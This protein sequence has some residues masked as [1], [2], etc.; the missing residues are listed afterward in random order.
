MNIDLYAEAAA[1][2][3]ASIIPKVIIMNI[4]PAINPRLWLRSIRVPGTISIIIEKIV[5]FH[6][7]GTPIY[8]MSKYVFIFIRNLYAYCH[9][10]MYW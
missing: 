7:F 8:D 4:K 2:M 5:L 6:N 1:L 10:N 9:C 3:P